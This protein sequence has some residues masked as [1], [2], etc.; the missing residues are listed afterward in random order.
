ML[1]GGRSVLLAATLESLT[2]CVDERATMR[3]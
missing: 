1:G 2:T 3:W